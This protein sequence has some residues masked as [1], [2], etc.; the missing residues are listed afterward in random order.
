MPNRL[1]DEASPYLLQHADNPVDWYPWGD[2]A[3]RRAKDEDKPIL[4]SVGYAACHWCHVMERESFEDPGTAALMNQHFVNVKVDREERPDIDGIYMDAVQAMSGS[5]GWP[6]TVFLTPDG[7]PFFAGTYFPPEDRHGL[8]GFKR[9]LVGLAEAWSDRRDDAVKQARAVVEAIRR[10]AAARAS[11]DPLSDG[12]LREAFSGLERSFDPEWGGFGRAPKFPQPMTLDFVFRAHLRGYPGALEMLTATL[13]RMATGGMYDQV[14]GGFHRYST[15]HRWHVP[16]FEKMLYDNAQLARLYARAWLLTGEDRYRRVAAGTLD[17]LLGE[18]RHGSGG[19]SSSQDADS[20]GVEGRFF[21]WSHDELV[22][23]GGEAVTTFLGALPEGN[24]EGTNVLWSP[25]DLH[26]IAAEHGMRDEEL[27]AAV[28][29]ARAELFRRREERVHPA[30][31]DKVLTSWNGLAISALT[32]AG[33]LFRDPRYVDAAVTAATFLVGNLRDE[34][35]WF[36]AWRD[37]RTGARAFLDDHAL[38]AA[39]LLDLYETTFDQRWL[40]EAVAAAGTILRDFADPDAG[41]FFTTAA[42]AEALVVRPKDLFDNAVPSGNSAAADVLLRLSLILGDQDLEHAAVGALRLVRDLAA[43]YPTGFGHALGAMDL[44]VSR[45]REVAV[46][47]DPASAEV[48]AFADVV[49]RRPD[50]N[51]VLAVGPPGSTV[52]LLADRGLVDGR[53]AAYVCERFVCQRPVTTP[54]E[55]EAQLA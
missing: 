28:E 39:G 38:L 19:F 37:G 25:L 47:G 9:V 17:Y 21:V 35:G 7:E 18:M 16:H 44:Y 30:T 26:V 13:D 36:R 22:E 42:G 3:L 43:R 50:P 34:D 4:L 31:D 51:R 5:G 11:N 45:A 49:W 32:E 6:M 52:P 54:A 20:E 27:A 14:G 48:R 53:A 40:D 41:G 15:D 33:R 29:A 10:Q 1:I 24:W 12:V 8:P 55:L 23:V 46:V 2:E